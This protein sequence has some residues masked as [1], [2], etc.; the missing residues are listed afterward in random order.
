[1][2]AT[3]AVLAQEA[4]TVQELTSTETGVINAF[5]AVI[6]AVA[7]VAAIRMVTTSNVVHAA[8]YLLVVLSAVAGVY[9]ILGAEFVAVTQVLV[10]LGA[11][12]VLLL[13]GVMLTRARI[14]TETDLDHE[15]RWIAGLVA[16][17]MLAVMSYSLWEG[18]RDDKLPASMAPQ[19]TQAVSDEIFSTYIV[20]FEALSVLLLAALIGAVVVARRD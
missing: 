8:L 1:M 20:P 16:A 4:E 5:F 10:Y 3:L 15:Q 6:A 2:I 11:I 12:M 13:F 17:G 7:I 14:G 19:R 9:V 18:F